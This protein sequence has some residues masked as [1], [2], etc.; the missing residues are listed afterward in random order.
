MC[1]YDLGFFVNPVSFNP[2]RCLLQPVVTEAL[3]GLFRKRLQSEMENGVGGPEKRRRA[4][5]G[6]YEGR[7]QD[8]VCAL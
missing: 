6:S 7:E 2:N 8:K 4:E 3:S 1:G 5:A